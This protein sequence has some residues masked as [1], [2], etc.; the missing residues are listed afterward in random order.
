MPRKEYLFYG[1]FFY[2]CRSVF[3]NTYSGIQRQPRIISLAPPECKRILSKFSL[4]ANEW[5]WARLIYDMADIFMVQSLKYR[6]PFVPRIF[7]FNMHC[8]HLLTFITSCSYTWPTKRGSGRISSCFRNRIIF[9]GEM[10]FRFSGLMPKSAKPEYG[11][12]R[13]AAF[14][15][16]H[17]PW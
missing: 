1:T 4:M 14:S 9:L 2:F 6:F 16:H 10:L 12:R 8:Y 15:Q 11:E 13:T 5:D 7:L 3:R 17:L